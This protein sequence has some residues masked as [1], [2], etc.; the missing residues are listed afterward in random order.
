MGTKKMCDNKNSVEIW[1]I[2]ASTRPIGRL[3]LLCS[4]APGQNVKERKGCLPP[5]FEQVGLTDLEVLGQGL[6]VDT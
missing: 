1:M 3:V 6:C 5:K 4:L 2:L